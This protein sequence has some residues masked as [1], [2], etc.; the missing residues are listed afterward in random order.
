MIRHEDDRQNAKLAR[1]AQSLA[2]GVR[3]EVARLETSTLT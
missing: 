2:D 3:Q 1:F